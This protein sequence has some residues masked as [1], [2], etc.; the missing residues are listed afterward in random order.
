MSATTLT[1]TIEPGALDARSSWAQFESLVVQMLGEVPLR[2]L[3]QALADAQE[4]LTRFG[5]WA[6]VGAGA[7]PAGAVFLPA[8]RGG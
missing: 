6:A 3:E 4:R 5:V 2:A 8:L 1:L 7:G